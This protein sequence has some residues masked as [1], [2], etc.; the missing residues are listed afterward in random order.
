MEGEEEDRETDR[1]T[2]GREVWMKGNNLENY[3]YGEWRVEGEE[4]DRETDWRTAGREVW[5]KGKSV[6]N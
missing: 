3:G 1:R 2:A 4:K 5:M 6:E